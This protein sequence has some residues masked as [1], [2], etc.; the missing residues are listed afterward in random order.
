[1]VANSNDLRVI[2]KH[3]HLLESMRRDTYTTE[4]RAISE[5]RSGVRPYKYFHNHNFMSAKWNEAI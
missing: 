5:R 4:E 3:F 1:M 2:N